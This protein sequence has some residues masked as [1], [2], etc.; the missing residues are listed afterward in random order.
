MSHR[1]RQVNFI[2]TE[3]I[4]YRLFALFDVWQLKASQAAHAAQWVDF[5]LWPIVGLRIV[6]AG[7]RNDCT[8]SVS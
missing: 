4:F 5:C 2:V 1:A 6:T 8:S 7:W 3:I